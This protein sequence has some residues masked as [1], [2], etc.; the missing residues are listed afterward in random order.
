MDFL[1]GLVACSLVVVAVILIAP[2]I[3]RADDI[4]IR[5]DDGHAQRIRLERPS[6]SI[7]QIEFLDDRKAGFREGPGNRF[8]R[9][10]S[11]TYG[12]NCGGQYGNVTNHL[13][14]ACDGKPLC[15]YVIDYRTIGDP[16]PGCPKDYYAEWQCAGSPQKETIAI[17]AEAGGGTIIELRCPG[18]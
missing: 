16:A 4:V 15:R 5:Y 7:R 3:A 2:N 9:V 8:I 12:R 1:K 18:R 6:D 13:A 17:N 11:G 10:V 14:Q